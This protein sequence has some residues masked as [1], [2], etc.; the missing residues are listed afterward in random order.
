[1]DVRQRRLNPRS[2]I[3]GAVAST[4]T[5]ARL[6][7]IDLANFQSFHGSLRSS[8]LTFQGPPSFRGRWGRHETRAP[9]ST[10]RLSIAQLRESG[11]KVRSAAQRFLEI[12]NDR[13]T[14]R[15]SMSL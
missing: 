9:V 5:G 6:N 2:V 8:S 12:K 1:M 3:Y 11:R 10:L 4:R 14:R 13:S 7:G 15:A